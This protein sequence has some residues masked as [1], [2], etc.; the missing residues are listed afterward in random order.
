DPATRLGQLAEEKKYRQTFINPADIGGRYSAVS[1]FG[2]VPASLIAADV[3][4]LVEEANELAAASAPTVPVAES[5]GIQLGAALGA[6]ARRGRDKLTFI[7]SPEIASLGSWIEQLV[8]EST[9]KDGKGIVPVDLEPV[10]APA[11]YGADRL[12]VYIRFG[13]GIDG[14]SAALDES[15]AALEKAGHPV[16]RI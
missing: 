6:L 14:A 8:A 10:G 13:E 5:P 2:L 16:V 15:V 3:T 1:Y 12:F 7:I 11:S 9:G 4:G